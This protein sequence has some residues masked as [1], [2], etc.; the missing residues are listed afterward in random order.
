[1]TVEDLR[2]RFDY[3]YW[4]NRRLFHVMEQ[5]APEQF[6]QAVAGSYGSVRNTMV[7]VLSA[8]WGWLE[9]C[10]GPPRGAQLSADD[11]PSVAA[12][13]AAWAAVEADV[14]GFLDTLRD[15][16]LG[17]LVEFV[18]PRGGERRIMAVG[19]LLQHAANHGVHHRGQVALLIR[20]LGYAPGN[21]DMLIYDAEKRRAATA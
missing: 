17:R 3:G 6:T 13:A 1:M 18:I 2:R 5:M 14:R 9:R 7:H 12:L 19:E 10:G 21:I 11:Y 8:E 16:D 20:L 4:A 15:D